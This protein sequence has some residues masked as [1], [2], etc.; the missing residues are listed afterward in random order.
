M[1][2]A[3]EWLKPATGLKVRF[4][5]PELGHIPEEGAELPLT[6]YYRR[7]IRDRDLVKA[8]RPKAEANGGK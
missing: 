6:A 2:R 8:R 5:Q 4:E 1:E 3:T 7:R